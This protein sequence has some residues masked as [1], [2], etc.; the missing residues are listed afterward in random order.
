MRTFLKISYPN[1][2]I[3]NVSNYFHCGGG[4]HLEITPMTLWTTHIITKVF[5]FEFDLICYYF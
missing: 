3:F 4:R 5:K 2:A 1:W